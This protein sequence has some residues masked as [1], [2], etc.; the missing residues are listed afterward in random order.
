MGPQLDK[1]LRSLSLDKALSCMRVTTMIKNRFI[2]EIRNR[3][4]NDNVNS[5]KKLFENLPRSKAKDPYWISLLALYDRL[6][7]SEKELIIR[8]VRQVS[9]DTTATMLALIDGIGYSELGEEFK[10]IDSK[11][12]QY[13]GDL[14]NIFLAMCE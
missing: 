5:Y 14:S 13:Q 1:L 12:N 10:L 11:G 2:V 7:S 8:V 4:V 9:I 3:V 6:S